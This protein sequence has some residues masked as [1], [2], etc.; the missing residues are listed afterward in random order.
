LAG[1]EEEDCN[2]QKLS[3]QDTQKKQKPLPNKALL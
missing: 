2:F 1:E 3:N